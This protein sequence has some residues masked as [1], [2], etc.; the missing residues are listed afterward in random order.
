[1]SIEKKSKEENKEFFIGLF[2]LS[3]QKDN[4]NERLEK[5]CAEAPHKWGDKVYEG[6]CGCA[7]YRLFFLNFFYHKK[8]FDK[9]KKKNVNNQKIS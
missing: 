7:D 3:K 2:L 6:A 5:G 8:S 9:E 4:N 1:M